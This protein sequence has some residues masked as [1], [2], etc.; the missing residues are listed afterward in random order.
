MIF[1]VSEAE[2][3]RQWRDDDE[4]DLS[5]LLARLRGE[6][7]PSQAMLAGTAFH[8]LLERASEGEEIAEAEQDGFRFIIE[9]DIELALAP[10]R[11]LRANK[12]YAPGI[13]I[14]GQLDV[15]DGRRV[16]DHKTTGRFD[17][18]RYLDGYQWRFYLDIFGADTFRWNVF[19]MREVEP[20]AYLVHHFHRLEQ[21]R[22]PKLHEDCARLAADIHG[23]ALE[24][25]PER[26]QAVAA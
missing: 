19:E 14:S 21:H 11:E 7:E 1:R 6:M 13:T 3:F 8:A 25:M 18:E 12:L 2:S 5:A 15:L 24:H 26:L 22:Y 4:S 10:I 17:P 9:V 20:H 16:E 23:F